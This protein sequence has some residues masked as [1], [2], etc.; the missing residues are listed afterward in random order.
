MSRPEALWKSGGRSLP[1][2]VL[3]AP[4]VQ[5]MVEVEFH[6]TGQ[7]QRVRSGVLFEPNEEAK[8][9]LGYADRFVS[10]TPARPPAPKP[11]IVRAPLPPL[12][13][14]RIDRS[15]AGHLFDLKGVPLD[16]RLRLVGQADGKVALMVFD[17]DRRLLREETYVPPEAPSVK[18]LPAAQP[19]PSGA[20]SRRQIQESIHPVLGVQMVAVG[21]SN[22][23]IGRF[24][25]ILQARHAILV[26]Y[27]ERCLF[28]EPFLMALRDRKTGDQILVA[29]M[30]YNDKKTAEVCVFAS[31]ADFQS[32]CREMHDRG[33]KVRWGE[34]PPCG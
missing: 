25:G 17:G 8:W 15:A 22:E 12:P 26:A 10:I 16:A 4:D 6:W 30:R 14:F 32:R 20:M 29:T 33:I 24:G 19:P 7:R 31:I 11:P 28:P 1:V 2:W 21:V 9:L 23:L 5:G 3:S 34:P 18:Q 13:G 27:S